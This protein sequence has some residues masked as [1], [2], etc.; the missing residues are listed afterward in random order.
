MELWLKIVLWVCGII[1]AIMSAVLLSGRGG[2]FISGYNLLSPEEKERYDEK[3]LCITMGAGLLFITV[4]YIVGL[5][6]EFNFTNTTVMYIWMA[7]LI[8]PAIP[9]LILGNTVCKKK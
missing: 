8:L 1:M 6:V 2:G 5:I 4:V 7:L 9:M 3:K